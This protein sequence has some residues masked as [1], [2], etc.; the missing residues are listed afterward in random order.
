[1]SAA[2]LAPEPAVTTVLTDDG[3]LVRLSGV[4]DIAATPALRASLLGVRPAGCDDVVVDADGVLA[5]D[6]AALAVLLAAGTWVADTGGR[7]SF[8]RMSETLRREVAQ[9]G[10]ERLLPMLESVGERTVAVPFPSP[11]TATAN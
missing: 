5:V 11:R 2:M 9:L 7:L 1:M 10:L 8:V 4:L 6:D 3:L